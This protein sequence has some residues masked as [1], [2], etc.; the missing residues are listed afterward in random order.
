MSLFSYVRS[1][2]A[3]SDHESEGRFIG[4]YQTLRQYTHFEKHPQ[5]HMICVQKRYHGLTLI[6]GTVCVWWI[7][8][9]RTVV[10]VVEDIKNGSGTQGDDSE[11]NPT[12][13]G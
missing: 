4:Q 3:R 6:H 2:F 12:G 10:S 1:T 13:L 11:T 5:N 7:C 9:L 8:F